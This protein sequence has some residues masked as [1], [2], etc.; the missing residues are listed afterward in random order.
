MTLVDA[1]T[2]ARR[3]GDP[4]VAIVDCRFN[5]TDLEWGAREYEGAH[6]PGAVFVDLEDELAGPRTG[7]NGRHPLPEPSTF[8]AV[9][10]RLGID[11]SVLVVAYDQD[12]GMYA[13]RL[14]WM[15]RW[16]GHP[17]AAVLDGGFAEWMRQGRPVTAGAESRPPRRFTHAP[18]SEM[19]ADAAEV[20]D[21]AG[22][23]GWL[24]VDARSPERFRGDVETLDT[25][26]GHIPGAVNHF[27][28][29]NVDERGLFLAPAELR[30]R[31]RATVGGT[32]ADRIV[33]YCGSGVTACHMV[34]A[35]EHA[36]LPGARLY[37][38]SWSEW[39]SDPDRPQEKGPARN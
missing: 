39:S 37:P 31:L 11:S 1:A 21:L 32:D 35:L 5:P 16:M 4:S 34:L 8:S 10:G 28:R 30:A 33:C 29:Q 22:R 17:A 20:A 13:S 2:L 12:A 19:V 15:L 27:F 9:L 6:I 3:L 18:R 38:G 24:L 25:A 7:V 14:W 36:G 26:A 23:P